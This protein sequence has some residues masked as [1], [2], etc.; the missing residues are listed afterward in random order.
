MLNHPNAVPIGLH[1]GCSIGSQ[2]YPYLG[3]GGE[4]LDNI[5]NIVAAFDEPS[6][7]WVKG[8][9]VKLYKMRRTIGRFYD[10]VRPCGRYQKGGN[11]ETIPIVKSKNNSVYYSGL[12]TCKSVWA[13]PVCSMKINHQRAQEVR[14]MLSNAILEDGYKGLFIT[15]TMPHYKNENLRR[16]RDDVTKA[17]TAMLNQRIY[18]GKN[19]LKGQ[20]GVLGFIKALEVKKSLQNGWHPHLHIC[21]VLDPKTSDNIQGFAESLIQLWTDILNKR[22]GRKA[23]RRAQQYVEIYDI[24][25]ISDYATKWDVA[26]ELVESHKKDNGAGTPV[27][28]LIEAFQETGD[29]QLIN[30]FV[31][32]AKAFKGANQL[33][34]SRGFKKQF[35]RG[36][37]EKTDAEA[38]TDMEVDEVLLELEKNVFK[39]LHKQRAEAHFLNLVQYHPGEVREFLREKVPNAVNVARSGD[40]P[41]YVVV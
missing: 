6:S 7:E 2:E 29:E 4:A 19:G 13:C 32:F 25:G 12:Q 41:K 39:E 24:D 40:P 14:H 33:T 21:F 37:D 36:M 30:D 3:P 17:F 11:S 31:C 22:T 28:G 26:K 18:K 20:Y 15:L 10:R 8:Q 9:R 23:L 16:L 27:F 34:Y 38:C 5:G 35:L 1:S